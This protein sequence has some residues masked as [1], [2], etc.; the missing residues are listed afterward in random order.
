M[1]LP[2]SSPSRR[3]AYSCR[4]ASIDS[5]TVPPERSGLGV[6]SRTSLPRAVSSTRCPP[7]W[8]RSRRFE[9]LFKPFLADLEARRDQQRV[10]L[11]L[12][13]LGRGGADIADQMADRGARRVEAREA[14]H[15]LDPGQFGQAH[16]DRGIALVGDVLGDLDRLV[17]L[18]G[19]ELAD[20]AVDLVGR[21]ARAIG[22]AGA[23]SRVGRSNCSGMMSTRKSRAVDRDRLAVAVDDPAAPRRD[24][25]QLDAVALAEAAGNARSG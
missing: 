22:R 3:A 4:P 14:A 21:R 18:G 17:A 7:G 19:L 25:D 5:W 2:D 13:F 9:R 6:S 12:I 23:A 16:G 1:Q 24:D 11:L 20:D 8:P 15:R 10:L